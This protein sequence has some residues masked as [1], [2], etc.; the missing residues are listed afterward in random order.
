MHQH[1]FQELFSAFLLEQKQLLNF[2]S[3]GI[4][5]VEC[6]PCT[7][8]ASHPLPSYF[9]CGENLLWKHLCRRFHLGAQAIISIYRY[10]TSRLCSAAESKRTQLNIIARRGDIRIACRHIAT[11]ASDVMLAVCGAIFSHCLAPSHRCIIRRLPA[12]VELLIKSVFEFSSGTRAAASVYASGGVSAATALF[13]Q[14][15]Q[16]VSGLSVIFKLC[17]H[18]YGASS[19]TP[20]II[21]KLICGILKHHSHRIR[22]CLT[23]RCIDDRP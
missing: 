5:A 16:S 15:F 17:R 1:S 22:L 9:H 3:V 7:F 20:H 19:V 2:V 6:S 14:D 13:L 4:S 12:W 8:A 23:S 10:D 11:S 18:K 21:S